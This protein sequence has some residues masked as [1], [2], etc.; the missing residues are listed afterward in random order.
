MNEELETLTAS[1]KHAAHI[2]A[3]IL[4]DI[5]AGTYTPE[6]AAQDHEGILYN[7]GISFMTDL[8]EY[9]LSE[10]IGLDN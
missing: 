6:Q 7:E 8:E 10:P 2:I 9:A 4:A 1:L 5:E 3:G